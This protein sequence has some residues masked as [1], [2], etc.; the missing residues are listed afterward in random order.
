[1]HE[2]TFIYDLGIVVVCAVGVCILFHRLRIPSILGYLL[3]G[4]LVGPHLFGDASLVKDPEVVHELAELGVIFL[5]FYIGM[6]FDLKRLKRM[7]MPS[8]LALVVQ[9]L[10]MLFIGMETAIL[11]GWDVMTGFFIG[12]FLSISSSMVSVTVLQNRKELKQSHGQ[13]AVGILIF[14]DILAVLLLVLLSGVG[15]TRSLQLDLVWL[16]TAGVGIFVVC[17]FFVGRLLAPKLLNFLEKVGSMELIVLTSVGFALGI[18]ILALRFDF[19]VALGAFVAGG[20]LSQTR[21]AKEIEEAM[22]P[23]RNLFGA[24][25]FVSTGMMIDPQLILSSWLIVLLVAIAVIVGKIGSCW[26]GLFLGGQPTKPAFRAAVVKSQIAEFSFIIAGLAV[27]L[28]VTDSSIMVL[29]VGVALVSILTTP[30]LAARSEKIYNYLERRM[31]GPLHL[32]GSFYHRIIDQVTHTMDRSTLIRLIKK[33]IFQITFYLILLTGMLLVASLLAKSLSENPEMEAHQMWI[34]IGV[35]LLTGLACLPFII[36]ILRNLNVATLLILESTFSNDLTQR[37]FRG[38]LGNL[39]N[40]LLTVLVVLPIA[41]LYFLA[42]SRFF[43]SGVG[44]IAFSV[45]LLGVGITFWRRMILV[46]SKIEYMFMESLNEDRRSVE[47]RRRETVLSEISK[48]YPWPVQVVAIRVPENCA[49]RRLIE[50]PFREQAGVMVVAVGRGEHIAFDPGPNTPL[51]PGDQVFVFGQKKQ[52]E[53]A[54]RIFR[55]SPGQESQKEDRTTF[56]IQKIYLGADS[57]LVGESL[58]GSNLR[59]MHGINVL[60][61]QRGEE[62]ITAPAAEEL[63]KPGD[64][65]FVIGNRDSIARFQTVKDKKN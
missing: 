39:I 57:A 50:F 3:A 59:R 14:E 17:V 32:V 40:L 29:A 18:G 35:W 52:I 54:K 41:I 60:G 49:G 13:L 11:M 23:L 56:D 31:P 44:L 33:P 4:V 2:Q 26:L 8:L 53:G 65:L 6:E 25:F 15:V 48:K 1:M 10:T 63:M 16:T 28:E 62:R 61:I 12:A 7:F 9:T 37:Y 45:V 27:S 42:A 58:A 20:I 46:N 21:M 19:S 36:S 5:M 47:E 38:R 34:Q 64:V 51:F 43:P 22:E 30:V 24:I 55:I